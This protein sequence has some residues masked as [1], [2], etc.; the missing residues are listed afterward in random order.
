MSIVIT[1]EFHIDGQW[2]VRSEWV[3]IVK[4][5]RE[6][7]QL[8]NISLW[9]QDTFQWDDD[10]DVCFVLDHNSMLLW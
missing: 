7:Y 3:I 4:A 10:D 5:K 6:N 8:P 2:R 9:E 1:E